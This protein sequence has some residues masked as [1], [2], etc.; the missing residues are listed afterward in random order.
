MAEGILGLGSGQAASLNSDLINKLKEAERKATVAP[1][2]TRI[3]NI[4]LE[5]EVFSEIDSKVAELLNAIKPFDLFVSGGTNAFSQKSATTTGDS[6]VFDAADVSSLNKGVTTVDVEK[7]AQKDVYQTNAMSDITTPITGLGDLTINGEIFLTEGKTYQ[8]LADEI[9][10][11]EG[12]NASLEQVGTNSYRIVIKSEESG[13]DNALSIG[14]TAASSLGLDLPSNHTLTAQN[15]DIKVDGISYSL[16]S[17]DLT[18]NGLKITALKEGI[19][20]INV[21]DDKTEVA[22]Q[23]QNFVKVYNELVATIDDSTGTDSPITNR[24]GLR[25]IVNQIKEKLFGQYG[26]NS[27]KSIFNYGFEIDK[28]GI[29]SLNETK[30]NQALDNDLSGLKELFIGKAESEGLGTQLK[31]VI[32]EMS[33]S[34]GALNIY[35]NDMTN[36]ELRLN[37]DKEKAEKLLNS[38][39]E[40][41]ALQFSAYGSLI[42]QMEASFSGLKMLIQQSTASN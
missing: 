2:E 25:E 32:D 19:S 21:V 37:Q 12:I 11:K 38:K 14:G 10:A 35:E 20:S 36:R 8:A 33:F 27:D 34:S 4:T 28:S 6:V 3:E 18:V 30:F 22:A 29:L 42:N 1:Y 16:S 15:M 23:M 7:L 41:L 26:D 39:Y 9:N 31:A 13:L 5:K 17:N 24:S 40:Q